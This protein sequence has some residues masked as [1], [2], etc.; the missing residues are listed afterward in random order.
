MPRIDCVALCLDA[1]R[2]AITYVL[3]TVAR[4]VTSG[5][6]TT[7]LTQWATKLVRNPG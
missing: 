2:T 6:A 3:Q 1:Q 5:I 7:I 4:L